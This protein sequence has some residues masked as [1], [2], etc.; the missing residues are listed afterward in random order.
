VNVIQENVLSGQT[1]IAL[2]LIARISSLDSHKPQNNPN[3]SQVSREFPELARNTGTLPGEYSI[4]LDDGA[5]GV[6]HA[7]RRQPAALRARIIDKL[8]EMESDGFIE[9]VE[10]P[11]EWVSSMVVAVRNDKIR[12]CIDPTDLN[13]VIK[14]EHYPMRTIEDVVSDIPGATVFSVLDAKSGFMQIKLDAKSSLLTTFNTP[15]GRYRW[16]RLPFGV[17]CAP[18]AFQKVMD[19]M[20]EGI[21][22][23]TAVMDDILIAGRDRQH[24]DSILKQ[25]IE[26]ACAFNLKLNMAKCRIRQ[27]AV[28]YVGHMVTRQGLKPD[29][30]KV[31]AV[32]EMP[33][34]TSKDDLRRFLGFVTYLSKFIPNLSEIDAPLRQVLKSDV[35]FTWQSTQAK[36][37]QKLIDAC[38][39]PPVLKFFDVKL[40]VEVHCDA[41]QHG[42]GGVLIQDGRP[43][44]YTSRSLTDVE[45]RY[46]QI[47]KEMLSIVHS[48]EKF[49]Q[50]IFG[51]HCIIYNDHKPLEQIF[52]KPL[53][54]APMRLQK[55]LLKLQWYGLEVHYRRGKEMYL[56]DTLSRAF[57]PDKTPE[58]DN[59][60]HVSM[61]DFLSVTKERYEQLQECTQLELS[62]LQSVIQDGW[63][64]NKQQVPFDVKQY[65]ESRSELVV[66]N[67]IIYKGMRIV[68]P[69]SLRQYMVKLIHQSH[70]GIVKCKQRAREV[71][72]WPA[73]HS[74]I[75]QAVKDCSKCA[76]FQNNQPKEPMKPTETP[77][78]PFMEVG[79][80]IF[81][82][83][84][85]HYIL[86]VDYYSKFIEVDELP[87][88][89][90]KATITALKSQFCRH[91]IPQVVRSD[92]GPQYSSSE[93]RKFCLEFGISH[94]TSSP[95]TPHSNGAAE[96]AVQTVK[97]MWK[98]SD[99]HLSLLDYRTTPLENVNLSPAQLLMGR[100]PR[101]LLP[102]SH[103]LLVPTSYNPQEVKRRL[104]GQKTVQKY[105]Y[106]SHTRDLHPLRSG[107]PVRLAPHPGCKTWSPGVALEHHPSPR[108]YLVQS[109]G[110]TYRRNR[111]DLREA[112]HTANDVTAFPHDYQSDVHMDYHVPTHDSAQPSMKSPPTMKSPRVSTIKP[113]TPSG[114]ATPNI[115]RSRC[116]REVRAPH[117]LDL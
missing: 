108:S 92:N 98:K 49:H 9:R 10:Q 102:A 63:P 48:C 62:Q 117:K 34:P 36:A 43:I 114:S 89:S 37:F 87:D 30:E 91:G 24:H 45:S 67:G 6:V 104:N 5:V 40:P 13:K 59:L 23:A 3:V 15:I 42:L 19:H 111:C 20:L 61:L 55:M 77:D 14:R 116:G 7:V 50:Y 74:D 113:H 39:S 79:T 56:P 115:V 8:H 38:C 71:L 112:T 103:E 99:K 28:P 83:D 82:L 88:M 17:K 107:Q 21:H 109:G 58:V 2:G 41:S 64:D 1:A 85:K 4:K 86:I 100:R 93:F 73:M 57:L 11:T 22:G 84:S 97:R 106:D 44:A 95:H 105:Y 53:L 70:L 29:P 81:E 33:V 90:S 16:L 94:R 27:A 80:D 46:A 75:E 12:I 31:K 69:P 76:E 47:E 35:L 54:S 101:N 26:R 96:K 68:V 18:E 25:V 65:W 51:K 72:Y 60:E 52:K 32:R 78:L 110:R 66:S